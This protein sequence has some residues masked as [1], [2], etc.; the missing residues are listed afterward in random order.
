VSKRAIIVN[1]D[2]AGESPILSKLGEVSEQISR[3]LD[4][5]NV[6]HTSTAR[7]SLFA[8]E[9][10]KQKA[11]TTCVRWEAVQCNKGREFPAV[12]N[13][14]HSEREDWID[15]PNQSKDTSTEPGCADHSYFPCY[16][17][18]LA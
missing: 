2:A 1:R 9:F 12:V 13:S 4:R 8:E 15:S 6:E 7:T 18:S 10:P 5:E 3:L 11:W 16:L 17:S 14:W